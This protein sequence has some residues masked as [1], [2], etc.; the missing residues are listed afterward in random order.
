MDA[1]VS[2][3][4]ASAVPGQKLV[5]EGDVTLA[6]R[7]ALPRIGG[8]VFQPYLLSPLPTLAGARSAA[9]A[10]PEGLLSAAAARNFSLRFSPAVPA[11]W[12]PDTATPGGALGSKLAT[13]PRAFTLKLTA[14]VPLGPV[15]V[16][17]T[18]AEE[19]KHGWVQYLALLVVSGFVAWVLRTVLFGWLVVETV[20]L[21]DAPRSLAKLHAS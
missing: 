12:V 11:V 21:A 3:S 9:E 6:Q 16:R 5:L 17:P 10:S 19:L 15:L 18:I 4:H 14:R 7:A 2:A 1:L 13:Q 8:G 20:V